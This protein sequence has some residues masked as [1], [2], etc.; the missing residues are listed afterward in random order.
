[1]K[2]WLIGMRDGITSDGAVWGTNDRVPL[3]NSEFKKQEKPAQQKV[4]QYVN[5]IYRLANLYCDNRN[6][7]IQMKN[8]KKS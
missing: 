3:S 6:G 4:N 1:M 5:E 2:N 8:Q 7:F